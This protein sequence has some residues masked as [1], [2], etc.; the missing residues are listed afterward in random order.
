MKA[1]FSTCE[2]EDGEDDVK[3]D[4]SVDETCVARLG[5]EWYRGQVVEV[6]GKEAAVLYV[7][8]G[9]VRKVAYRDLR[10]PREVFV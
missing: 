4:W 6:N 1:Y 7:D 8:L 9:N 10:V 5:N 2:L 3:E